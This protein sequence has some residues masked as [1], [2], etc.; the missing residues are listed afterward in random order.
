[1]PAARRPQVLAQQLTRLGCQQADVEIIP[2]HLDPLSDP[3]RWGTVVRGLDFDAAIQMDRALA[4]PVV[5][6]RLERERSER[7][8]FLGKHRGDLSFRGAVDARVG[9][10]RFPAIQVR[11]CFF[12]TLESEPAQRGLLRV[13]DARFDFALAIGIAHA[14]RE[15]DDAVV[16]QHVAIHRI[17]RG[18]VD[19]GRQHALFQIVE[20]DDADGATEPTKRAFVELRPDLRARSPHEQPDRFA[21]AAE[22]QDKE[23]RAAVLSG[24]AIAHHRPLTVVDLAFFVMVTSP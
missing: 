20:D 10:A 13:P 11:L 1:M 6:K 23:A 15:R 16:G 8:S 17:E 24:A 19:V 2:L 18:I 9:P 4:V 22:R 14:A 7:G 3:T 12:E 21:R 5:A